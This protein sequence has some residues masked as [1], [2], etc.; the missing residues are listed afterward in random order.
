VIDRYRNRHAGQPIAVLGSGPTLDLFTGT[1]P[2]AIAVNG[3]AA[4]A[5]PYQYFVCGD[6]QSPRRSW[7]YASRRH[8]ARRIVASFLAPLDK[9][10]YPSAGLRV[11]LRLDLA[12]RAGRRRSLVSLY[13]Y[14]PFAEP[15]AEHGWFHYA[16]PDFP[17][18]AEDFGRLL[19]AGRLLHG[20]TISGVAMQ[21]ALLMGASAIHLYGCSM[22]NDA[23]NNY[24]L[25]GSKGR[26]TPLQRSNLAS[27]IALIRGT[28]VDVVVHPAA[29]GDSVGRIR[30]PDSVRRGR[31]SPIE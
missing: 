21:I 9:V 7:F 16:V 24:C 18:T 11:R 1:E 17:H 13:D 28:G 26:T 4:C 6:I 19:A 27:L 23:G 22:D 15:A 8:D 3:A 31:S 30:G 5:V 12:W 10:L 20:A 2:V 29:G 25:P 14:V